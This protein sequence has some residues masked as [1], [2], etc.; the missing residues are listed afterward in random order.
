MSTRRKLEFH[1]NAVFSLIDNYLKTPAVLEASDS[2]SEIVS[3]S[4][5]ALFKDGD[6]V[7]VTVAGASRSRMF[8]VEDGSD[9]RIN[10]STGKATFKSYGRIYTIRAFQDLDGEWA[11]Q[12]GVAVPAEALEEMYMQEVEAAFTPNAPT[13]GEDLYAAVNG[14]TG[15]V[16]FLVYSYPGGMYTRSNGAWFKVPFGDETLDGLEIYDV[17]PKFIKVFD[18]ADAAGSTLKASDADNYAANSMPAVTAAG[19]TAQGESCPTATQDIATNLANRENAIKTAAYGPLNPKE[20]NDEFWQDKAG[21]W[22]VT[23]DEARK[24][25]CGTC[26]MFIRTSKMLDCIATGLESGDSSAENAWDAID[27]AELGYCEAF[28]FKC[29]AS[30]TCNAWVVGGPITDE[31][32]G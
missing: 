23:I 14:D 6:D 22:T 27:T 16:K 26:V 9:L 24:S 5:L 17:S 4:E 10:V 32:N 15:E 25:T 30:R 11:S 13:T 20:P 28:D 1:S 2:E 29:A 19:E 7:Y 8:P 3:V 31:V 12:L 18:K 21:R